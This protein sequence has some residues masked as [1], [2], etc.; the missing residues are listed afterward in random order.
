M[1]DIAT[2]VAS[3]SVAM[4]SRRWLLLLGTNRCAHLTLA[5]KPFAG[6]SH[7]AAMWAAGDTANA[8]RQ[9][10]H[11]GI[12]FGDKVFMACS[13]AALRCG[14]YGRVSKV[15]VMLSGVPHESLVSK[16]LS[17]QMASPFSSGSV[18]QNDEQ[19]SNQC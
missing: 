9:Y 12:L 19:A 14:T 17:G 11:G 18:Q 5:A 10:C 16:S 4:P 13:C 7:D 15:E 8:V 1:V 3:S 6:R 2:G